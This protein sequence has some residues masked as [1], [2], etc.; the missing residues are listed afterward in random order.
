[1]K[2]IRTIVHDLNAAL[3][4]L[5]PPA[6]PRFRGPA[7]AAS[8]EAAQQEL[9][10]ALDADLV[11]FLSCMDGQEP[12]GWGCLGDPIVPKF[13][14]GPEPVHFSGWGWFLGIDGIVE[15]TLLFREFTAENYEERYECLGPASF[16]EEYL[17]LVGSD[18]PTCIAID[19][20]PAPGGVLGQI[21]AINDQPNYVVVLAPSFR[22]FL[23]S[24]ADGY[25][26]GRFEYREGAW[27]EP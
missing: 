16:H 4:K 22:A 26:E 11:E 15:R 18:N 14:F 21:V 2:D 13:R 20:R 5:D 17:Q 7:S 8:I 1:L 19:L 27:S 24:V 9:G 12:D 25:A 3:A 6:D 23:Q 10:I